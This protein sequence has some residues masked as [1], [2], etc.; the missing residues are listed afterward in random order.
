MLMGSG[1][2]GLWVDIVVRAVKGADFWGH[3]E[4]HISTAWLLFTGSS[5]SCLLWRHL[6]LPCTPA[7][8]LLGWPH[9]RQPSRSNWLMSS[10]LGLVL[11]TVLCVTC[12]PSFL[13]WGSS[14]MIVVS[15][16]ASEGPLISFLVLVSRWLYQRDALHKVSVGFIKH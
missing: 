11:C 6:P 16:L 14:S 4:F 1:S 12:V 5:L 3:S 7:T 10:G 2:W 9:V 13:T 8:H 15:S